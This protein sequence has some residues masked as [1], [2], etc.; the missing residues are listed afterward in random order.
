MKYVDCPQCG[1]K[2]IDRTPLKCVYCG[3][4]STK[5]DNK[6][7]LEIL[8]APAR[9]SREN[10]TITQTISLILALACTVAFLIS[11]LYSKGTVIDNVFVESETN[12]T[13]FR[14]VFGIGTVLCMSVFF[15]SAR[16][17]EKEMFDYTNEIRMIYDINQRI[18]NGATLED[19]DEVEQSRIIQYQTEKQN[20]L[21]NQKTSKYIYHK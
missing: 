1:N 14:Y 21:L 12:I 5:V 19:F 20:G 9:P 18:L 10:A 4:D 7:M 13:P 3:Y 6:Q 17:F 2:I 8:E 15:S 16:N 11:L